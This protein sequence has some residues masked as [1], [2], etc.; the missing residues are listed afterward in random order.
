MKVSTATRLSISLV[1]LTLSV[2]L[3][4]QSIGMMPDPAD[5]ALKGRKDL[6]ESLAVGCSMAAQRG[7]LGAIRDMAGAILSHDKDLLSLGL[8]RADG[9]LLVDMGGHV[10]RWQL[11]P[12]ERSNDSFVQVPIFQRDQQWGTLEICFKPL[13]GHGFLGF[14]GHPVLRLLLFTSA[15]AYVAYLL[16]LRKTLRY[17][18]PSSVIPERVKA[19]LDTLAEG[20][21]VL[22]RRERVVLANDAFGSL[23]GRAA[24]QLTGLAAATLPWSKT[25]GQDGQVLFPWARTLR[26]GVGHRGSPIALV[27]G[28]HSTERRLV[29]NCAPIHADKGST[30]GVLLTFDDVTEIEATNNQLRETLDMLGRSR[31]EIERQN[32]ELQA[33]ATTDPLTGCRNRRSFHAEFQS[34]WGAAMRYGKSLACVMV[35]V[36]FF[37]KINDRYGHTTG[38]QVL[39]HVASIL[40][41]LAR[42]SDMV[43]RYGGEEFCM[44]LPE[45][46]VIAA[47]QAAERFR[48]TIE[49]KSC[50]GVNVTVSVG[51]STQELGA[52]S[53]Q[54][55][56]DQADKCLYAAKRGGRNRVVR[57]DEIRDTPLAQGPEASALPSATP[58]PDR[59]S[60]PISFH[61]VTALM[62]AL[63]HRDKGTADHS[64]RVADLCAAAAVGLMSV[65]DRFVLEVGALLHDIGKLGVPDA[66]LLKPGELN[67]QE[68]TIMRSHDRMGVEIIS[69]AFGSTELTE[70]VRTHHAQFA[71][72]AFDPTLPKGR[73]IPLGARILALADAYD[74]MVSNRPYRGGRDRDKAFEEL[75]RCS[76]GQFD[77]D[78]VEPFIAAVLARDRAA[79]GRLNDHPSGAPETEAGASEEL[80]DEMS[81]RIRLEV[82]RLACAAEAKDLACL[83]EVAREVVAATADVEGL[84]DFSAKVKELERSAS[85]RG[86]EIDY[87][88]LVRVVNELL[89]QCRGS[90]GLLS[91]QPGA[92]PAST[93]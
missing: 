6:C 39:Q 90:Q 33:L 58:I 21:L 19:M 35:D 29:L 41:S 43:C 30:R 37:K 84:G 87:D 32:K 53:P 3:A 93:K 88:A 12:G 65:K 73:D 9:Q 51:I 1:A 56:L 28:E 81:L 48:A 46:D 54:A 63:A 69:A 59:A 76:G 25:K 38:D 2:L 52:D 91:A 36:D 92:L 20:V 83:A 75:R 62:S 13:H 71:C 89:A 61:A 15:L 82:E 57:W 77:P 8:R 80:R 27:S 42:D 14:L 72:D 16:Y 10:G 31:D 79:Q 47:S 70:I 34:R 50:G 40:R 4:A 17:L 7:D 44:L 66:I 78:L 23:V 68:W 24:S 86:S 18:D 64:R 5:A 85:E 22:D 60:V 49:S 74:A 26:T 11:K 55:L 45:A 67:E